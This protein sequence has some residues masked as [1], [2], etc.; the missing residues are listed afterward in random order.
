LSTDDEIIKW[1]ERYLKGPAVVAIDAPLL[2]PNE[3]GRRPCEAE[4]SREYG[5]RKAGPHSSNRGRLEGLHGEI[6]GEVLAAHLADLGFGDPWAG[7]D[8]TVLEVYPHPAIIE[9][10][11]LE[12]RLIYKAKR[13]VTVTQRRQGLRNLASLLQGL[14]QAQPP[15]RGPSVHIPDEA[16]GAALKA[17]EDRL[18]A[19]I[20]AWIAEVWHHCADRV[21]L[22]GDADRGHIAVPIGSCVAGPHGLG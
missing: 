7:M 19:R 10:F 11:G 17:I 6:R 2:V 9:V 20:C 4:L 21:R 1:V 8:R 5:S 15:L 12:E 14:E 16:R 22:F 13:G 3:T 18:D